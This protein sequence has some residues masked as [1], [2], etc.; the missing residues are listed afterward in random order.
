MA[1]V[2][3]ASL[4]KTQQDELVCTYA[5]LILH[6]DGAEINAANM[7]NLIK[8][9]NC[10]VEGY[11]PMLFAK[12]IKTTG[13][14]TLIAMGSGAGGGGGGGGGAGGGGGGEP[15]AFVQSPIMFDPGLGMQYQATTTFAPAGGRGPGGH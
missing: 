15:F 1:S 11:W 9:A 5:A 13:M 7:N 12:M 14:D 4:D 3:V 2:P 6:D 8:A 10:S